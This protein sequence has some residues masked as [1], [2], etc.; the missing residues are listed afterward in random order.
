VEQQPVI[1]SLPAG[2][3]LGALLRWCRQRVGL[4]QEELAARAGVSDRTVRNL[5]TDQVR[6]PRSDT[7]RLLADALRL[8][9]WERERF[10]AAA[11]GDPMVSGSGG[12]GAAG[13]VGQGPAD[14]SAAG[15]D[16]QA[17][18]VPAQLPLDVRGFAGRGGELARLDAVLR[19]AAQQPTAVVISAL[20]GAPGVGKTALALHWAHRVRDRFPDGQLYVNLRGFDLG[21]SV[22]GPGEAV[23]GFL[24]AF[25]VAPERIP[26]SLDAQAALYRSRLAGRRVLVV[27]DDARDAE[28][29]RPLLPGS[30]GCLVVVTSRNHLTSLVVNEGAHPLI[31]DVLSITEAR[32]LLARRVGRDRVTA[33]P[34]AVQEIIARCARLPLA[35]AIVASRAATY[36]DFPLAVL[37]A[38]LR[39]IRGGLDALGGLGPLADLR[40]VFSSSYHTLSAPAAALFRQ[41]GLHPGPD[42]AAPAAASLAA[43]PIGPVRGLLAELTHA[44]LLTEHTPGR[45]TFH[46]LLR[47][48]ATELTHTLDPDTQRRAATHRMLDHYLH[49]AHTAAL[50]LHPHRDPITLA[51]PQPAVTTAE[52]LTNHEQALTWFITEHS[53]LLAAIHHAATTGFDRSTWQLAWTL[54]DYLEWRGHWDDSLATQLSALDA[55]HRDA[56]RPGQASTHGS[57]ARAYLRLGCYDE[58]YTHL[59]QALDIRRELHDQTGQAHSHMSLADLFAR[60]DRHRE[61]LGHAQ[62]A[63]DLFRVAGHMV[64]HARALNAVGWDHA[65][66]SEYQQALTYCQQALTLLS[67]LGDRRGQ[68][69]TWDSLGYAHHHLGEHAEAA[70]CYQHAIDLY[71]EVGARYEEADTLTRLGDTHRTSGAI[72]AAHDAWQRA[73]AILDHLRHPD[74]DHI[75][76]KLRQNHYPPRLPHRTQRGGEHLEGDQLVC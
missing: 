57:L 59:Q 16:Q 65:Q 29:V 49:T 70:A 66:L 15:P 45:Y 73:L 17:P 10:A 23:R 74:A 37:A 20:S 69:A 8:S 60:Q 58:A 41:L 67:E 19:E 54:A 75:R 56:D 55:T 12:A 42:I 31:L 76:T 63:L 33:D 38:E 43:A 9:G 25:A 24:D 2:G 27:L 6:V 3:S 53:V 4:S 18:V 1:A 62:H 30:P 52:H 28:Q 11:R 26:A 22:I 44:H 50:L 7:V 46:D 51:P 5:E 47:S 40:A 68:A 36:P 48:Y 13:G 71:R 39:N 32:D 64:G 21:G 61:A 14:G 72:D 34:Q 35:L